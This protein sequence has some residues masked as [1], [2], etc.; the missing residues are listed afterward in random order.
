MS[1]ENLVIVTPTHVFYSDAQSNIG[2]VHITA[3]ARTM[4]PDF[5]GI[6]VYRALANHQLVQ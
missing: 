4:T 3:S 2:S 6:A 1:R 5:P